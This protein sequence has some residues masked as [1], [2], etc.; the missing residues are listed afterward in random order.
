MEQDILLDDTDDLIIENGDFKIG[1]S[2]TQDVGLILRMNQGELK[3]DPLL[4]ANLIQMV[5]SNVDD[6]ELQTRVKLHLQRDG[7]DYEALKNYIKLNRNI[8]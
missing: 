2:L 5:K 1:E 4:G 3:E 7:K 6:D 8:Q